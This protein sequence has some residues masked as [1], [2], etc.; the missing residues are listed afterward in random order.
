[1]KIISKFVDFYEYDCYK[2]GEPD[3][4]LIWKR[5]TDSFI[6]NYRDKSHRKYG[7]LYNKY[8]TTSYQTSTCDHEGKSVW[9]SRSVQDRINKRFKLY[10]E[11]VGIYPYLYYIPI[12]CIGDI[13]FSPEDSYDCLENPG[14]IFEYLPKYE[15]TDSP[16]SY[17]YFNGLIS[18]K[19][20]RSSTLYK[21]IIRT[22]EDKTVFE[23]FD[24]PIF[25]MNDYIAEY[26]GVGR[27]I[28]KNPNLLETSFLKAFPNI[29]S[30]RDIYGDI[31]NYLWSKKQEPI[32]DPDNKTKILSHGFDL[33]T[34]FRKM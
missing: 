20:R 33:K 34:S 21:K 15:L 26:G 4:S 6:Y 28:I 10:E 16:K 24:C 30:E 11:L 19:S 17:I 9:S 25:V 2:Y 31:E 12:I 22:V 14:K 32:S 27:E 1:M 7:E 3:Q 23:I 18:P 5:E 13:K 29:Q 8:F